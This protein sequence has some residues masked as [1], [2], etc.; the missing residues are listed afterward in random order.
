MKSFAD[1]RVRQRRRRF[2][3]QLVALGCQHGERGPAQ[4][5]MIL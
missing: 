5:G 1:G 3:R 4:A 2:G